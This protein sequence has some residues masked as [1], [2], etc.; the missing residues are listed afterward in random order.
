MSE[1]KLAWRQDV[2]KGCATDQEGEIEAEKVTDERIEQCLFSVAFETG[3]LSRRAKPVAQ[4]SHIRV[5][6]LSACAA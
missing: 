6:T 3:L 1:V 4:F 5:L 2:E